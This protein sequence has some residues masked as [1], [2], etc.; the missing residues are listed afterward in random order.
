[1]GHQL[2]HELH[3]Q[4]PD[5]SAAESRWIWSRCQSRPNRA[6]YFRSRSAS[7]VIFFDSR[8]AWNNLRPASESVRL[9]WQIEITSVSCTRSKRS[10]AE[11]SSDVK[12][13]CNTFSR[14]STE[15][16][17]GVLQPRV[18][19]ATSSD[20]NSV[21]MCPPCAKVAILSNCRQHPKDEAPAAYKD[22]GEVLRS[23]EQAGLARTVAKLKARFVIKDSSE[24]DD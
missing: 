10:I 15:V 3:H 23:V 18:S 5:L 14:V 13:D 11:I 4:S 22:F 7:L 17:D 24:A 8:E 12:T 19:R 20:T 9:R 21:V 1:M 6:R 16:S 2:F